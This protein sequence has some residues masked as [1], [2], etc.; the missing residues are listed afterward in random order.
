MKMNTAK[1]VVFLM[2]LFYATA[3]FAQQTYQDWLKQQKAAQD[4]AIN[5][6]KTKYETYK[7]DEARA[8]QKFSEEQEKAFL[9]FLQQEWRAVNIAPEKIPDPTPKPREIPQ[10]EPQKTFGNSFPNAF[11]IEKEII[12]KEIELLEPEASED[13]SILDFFSGGQ[14]PLK[15]SFF[16]VLLQVDFDS[17][18]ANATLAEPLSKAAISEFWKALA[19]TKTDSLIIQSGR[20]KQQMQ[21]NDWGFCLLLYEMGDRIFPGSENKRRLFVWFVLTQTGYDARVGYLEDK[22]YLVLPLAPEIYSTLRLNINNNT[23]YLANLDG[24]KTRFTSLMIY[25]GT[26]EA[27][28]FPL[29]LDVHRLPAIHK[30]KM[31]RTLKFAYNGR[32]HTIEVEYRK[33][34]VDFFYRYPQTSSSLYFQASLSPEAHNSLVKGLRPLIAN[35]PEAEKVDIIL[36]FVQRAFEYETDEVQFGWEKPLFPEETL[37]YPYSDCEDRAVLFAYLVRNLVGLDVIG[38]DYPGHI[39]TAVKF[40]KKISGDF[41]MYQNEKYVI[42][43]ATY[44]GASIGQAMP[45]HKD[46]EVTF[47]PIGVQPAF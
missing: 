30:S 47:I 25:S 36:S 27:A 8:F 46:A 31:Q 4:S 17:D 9:E 40:S 39:S 20:L 11:R 2:V 38:L 29:K 12:D 37:F 43:D 42:C 16:D 3:G 33:D 10:T 28:K 14:E 6:E 26:F 1:I 5:S 32:E 23:Y 24:E 22:V 45:E 13:N 34:L 41:V 35:R 44:I 21:L 19:D 15:F 7:A 18:I